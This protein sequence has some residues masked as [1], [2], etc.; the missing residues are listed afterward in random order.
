MPENDNRERT[1]SKYLGMP[2]EV[3][4]YNR[5]GYIAFLNRQFEEAGIDARAEAYGSGIDIWIARE[6]AE[7][8][9]SL[10]ARIS[11]VKAVTIQ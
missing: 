3:H 2:K 11:G 1:P 10:M 9:E 5:A 8:F 4:K 7:K 6:D